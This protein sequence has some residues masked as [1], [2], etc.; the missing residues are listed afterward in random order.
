MAQEDNKIIFDKE[1][2]KIGK[3][4]KVYDNF[5]PMEKLAKLLQFC[6]SEVCKEH[7]QVGK[8]GDRG[9]GGHVR[10]ETRVVDCLGLSNLAKSY[11]AVHY[12]WYLKNVITNLVRQ[13]TK[14]TGAQ[15]FDFRL[16]DIEVLRYGVG[17]K[18]EPHVDA[19]LTYPRRVS[20]IM[21]LNNDY[22]GG[23]LFFPGVGEIKIAPNRAIVWPSNYVYTHGVKPITKGTRYSIVSWLL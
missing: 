1:Q 17:G 5:M 21:L 6:N 7:W 11:T 13:Y 23:E 19:S 2:D 3:W 16:H 18:Y 15:I 8:V 20:M 4:I 14:D 12:A 9:D 10:K 22:E